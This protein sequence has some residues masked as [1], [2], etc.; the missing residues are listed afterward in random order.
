MNRRKMLAGVV[1]GGA[2]FLTGCGFAHYAG[3]VREETSVP[4]PDQTN[5]RRFFDE[6][7]GGFVVGQTGMQ[8]VR[9]YDGDMTFT[10]ATRTIAFDRMGHRKWEAAIEYPAAAIAADRNVYVLA[11]DQVIALNPEGESTQHESGQLSEATIDWTA[12]RSEIEWPIGAAEG[13][14]YGRAGTGVAA[15]SRGEI[16]WNVE[17]S[18]PP[19]DLVPH[20][21]GVIVVES[22]RVIA[23]NTEGITVWSK[24][25]ER[26][27]SVVVKGGLVAGRGDDNLWIVDRHTGEIRW[28]QDISS[29][30]GPPTVGSDTVDVATGNGIKRYDLESGAHQ[31][32]IA[33]GHR[34]RSFIV[35]T[36]DELYA[37]TA[38]GQVLCAVDGEVR[39]VRTF[40]Q[41]DDPIDGWVVGDRVA[42]LYETGDIRWFQRRAEDIP[43]FF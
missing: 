25:T 8:W 34:P 4:A 6:V 40:D 38:G 12:D 1:T 19:L 5:G 43:L 17:L 33:T 32:D 39:W 30:G 22:D 18:E 10:T 21:A 11:E 2:S 35:P 14:V 41:T 29:G 3:A 42:F 36:A 7:D 16:Q 24:R 28:S 15:L 13:Y 27:A 20:E 26:E 23:L 37:A 9:D 31:W